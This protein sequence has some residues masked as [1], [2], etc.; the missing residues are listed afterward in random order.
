MLFSHDTALL[1]AAVPTD[2]GTTRPCR[3]PQL[4][5]QRGALSHGQAQHAE[6]E[7]SQHRPVNNPSTDKAHNTVTEAFKSTDEWSGG[8]VERS[9]WFHKRLNEIESIFKL[10][11]LCI[12]A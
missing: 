8:Q 9:P 11:L 3:N 4:P 2:R 6:Q 7:R 12:S 10:K 1:T 5:S